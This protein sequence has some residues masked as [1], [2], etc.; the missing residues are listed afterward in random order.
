MKSMLEEN[1]RLIPRGRVLWEIEARC[2]RLGLSEVANNMH[3]D[4][5]RRG[6]PMLKKCEDWRQRIHNTDELREYQKYVR[7]TFI[8]AIGG[9]P[10]FDTPLNPQVRRV[11]EIDGFILENVI[12]ESRPHTYVTCNLYRPL[13]QDGPVPGVMIPLGHTDEGKAFDE[14]QRVAQMLVKAGFVVLTMDPVGEGERFEHFEPEIDFEPIQGCSGEHDL[15]DWKCKLMGE[16]L[17]R[18]FVHDGMRA[19]EYLASRSE[20]DAARVAVTGHSGGGTQTS[21]LMCAA[22]DRIAAA[23]PC[24]YTTDLEAMIDDGKDPDNEMMWPGVIAAGIDYADIIAGMAPKPVLLLTNRYDFF[25]REGADRTLSRIQQL[26]QQV[27]ADNEPQIARTYTGHAYTQSLAEAVTH[28]LAQHLMGHDV[29]VTGFEYHRLEPSVLNCTASGQ[30]VLEFPD[31]C[32]V[33][34]E[35]NKKLAELNRRKA[36]LPPAERKE[37]AKRWLKETLERG[38]EAVEPHVRVYDEGVCA[39]YIY[40][41]VVWRAQK[42]YFNQGVLLRDMRKGDK[43]LPTVIA[44]WPNGTHAIERHSNWIHRQCAAGRQVLIVDVAAVGSAEPNKTAN[45]NMYIGWSTLFTLQSYFIEMG[46]SIAGL[47]IYQLMQAL[48]VVP[49]LPMEQD[50]HFSFYGEDD[51]AFYAKAAGWLTG[52]PVEEGGSYQTFAE[53]VTEKYH[54]QTH[55]M[56]W[57][58][59]GVLQYLD[60]EDINGYLREDGLMI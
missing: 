27:G 11:Q 19:I 1:G 35:L 41:V 57:E 43:P 13:Q 54:D 39:H 14:Y 20:V 52:T 2:R 37:Q 26:W 6:L 42:G 4:L 45:S 51:F 29:D 24:S 5:I 55:T 15:L 53:I 59:P 12:F 34:D 38:H 60:M 33:Q 25:P 17:A 58:L 30:V 44:I 3:R 18:Y 8:N 56:D 40:R 23:A 10:S 46:D 50:P 9:L 21:M 48:R 36:A 47:R 49:D 31:L 22:A 7:E 16:S 32:T 28:F